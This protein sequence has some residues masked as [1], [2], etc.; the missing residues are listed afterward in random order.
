MIAESCG[1]H[2]KK[3]TFELGGDDPFIVLNDADVKEAAKAAYK[4][5]M[6]CNGQAAINAKRFIIQDE[7][8]DEFKERLIEEIESKTVIGDP[9]NLKTNLGPMG[10]NRMLKKLRA[11]VRDAV[12]NGG[13]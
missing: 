10:T 5:R 3:A 13:G 1:E 12:D 7:V 6:H 4:S 8:Y 2:L 9:F 11:Q